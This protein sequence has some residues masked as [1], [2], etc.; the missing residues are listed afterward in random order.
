MMPVPS[1]LQ[2][3]VVPLDSAIDEEA[4]SARVRCPCA[5]ARFDLLYPGH[6]HR[7]WLHGRVGNV[8]R[9]SIPES[10]TFRLKVRRTSSP[11]LDRDPMKIGGRM[12]SAGSRWT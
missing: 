8:A 1:H 4:L 12:R 9:Q 7:N 2:G 6:T 11:R 5:D 10:F 3:L